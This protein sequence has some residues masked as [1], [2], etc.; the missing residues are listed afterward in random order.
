MPGKNP[1][2]YYQPN[3]LGMRVA[4]KGDTLIPDAITSSWKFINDEA[5]N[6]FDYLKGKEAF[7]AQPDN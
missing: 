6:L 7:R 1:Y 4:T 2:F 5:S 3:Q